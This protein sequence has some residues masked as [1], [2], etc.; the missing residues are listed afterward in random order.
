VS[1]KRRSST[2]FKLDLGKS[3]TDMGVHFLGVSFHFRARTGPDRTTFF[4]DVM[5]SASRLIAW[6]FLSTIKID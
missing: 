1:G 6:K 5:A 2:A 4:N 3:E